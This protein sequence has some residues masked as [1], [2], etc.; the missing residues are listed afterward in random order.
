[1]A[2]DRNTEIKDETME[3]AAGGS[4]EPVKPYSMGDRVAVKGAEDLGPGIIISVNA[5]N[6]FNV[7]YNIK[8]DD[9]KIKEFSHFTLELIK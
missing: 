4:I 8:F 7:L 9:G 2:D 6:I 1:M 3:N 5:S